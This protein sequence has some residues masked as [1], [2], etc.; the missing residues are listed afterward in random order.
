MSSIKAFRFQLC[1]QPAQSREL[2]R[3]AGGLRW[4]WNQALAEQRARHARGEP[5]AGFA[6]M[7]KWLTAWRQAPG[8]A[9]LASGPVHTQQQVLRR[10]D[11]SYKRF[12]EAARRGDTRRVKPPRFKRRGDEP[13]MRFPDAKQ[14]KLDQVN[15]RI[16]LPKLG[17]LRLRQSRPVTG[18]LRN[19]SLSKEGAAWFCSIQT[20]GPD[21]APAGLAPSRGI[22]MGLVQ[23]ATLSNGAAVAPLKA[24]AE[25]QRRL[26]RYQRS[27]SR[28]KKGSCN[29]KK[30]IA[31]LGNLHRRIARQRADW[32]HKLSSGLVAS[33]PVI[34]IEDLRVAAMSASARGTS[35]RPGKNVRQK[36]GLNR[37]ILDAAWAEF[38]RQLEYKS[39][40]VGGEVIAV[41]AAYTSQRCATCGHI[42]K[43]N[44]TTQSSFICLACGHADNADVNAAKNILA[45][46]HAVWA[47]REFKPKACGEDVRHGRRASAS[48][49]ASAKQ[50]PSEET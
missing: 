29:C 43:G 46:G 17:Q 23:F 26:R 4:V 5:Y 35:E 34:A 14:F 30:A 37:G 13:G 16:C 25:Q 12:F 48:R 6:Q 11:E 9:W 47:E 32:L 22:D 3:W 36:A 1:L 20:A 2:Q 44:R 31:R 42:D 15:G 27:V 18:E 8:T 39:A 50:E 33:H 24:M 38:R 40:A 49:A 21:V 45:A 7:C 19:V 28:K 10:L 41:P